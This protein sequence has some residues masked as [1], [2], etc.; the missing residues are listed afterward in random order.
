LTI[1]KEL[2]ISES[3]EYLKI[4]QENQIL[5]TETARHVVERSELQELRVEVERMKEMAASEQNIEDGFK[6]YIQNNSELM[7][8]LLKKLKEEVIK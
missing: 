7:G 5:Q 6:N 4:K 3:S 8:M 1:Q 2:N